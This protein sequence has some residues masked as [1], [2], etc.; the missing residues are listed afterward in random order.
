MMT[1]NSNR[2]KLRLVYESNKV[3][4]MLYIE[5]SIKRK[6]VSFSESLVLIIHSLTK[7]KQ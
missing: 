3:I 6:E 1:L 4:N 7:D 5:K 2:D